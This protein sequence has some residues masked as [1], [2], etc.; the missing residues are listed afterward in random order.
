[1]ASGVLLKKEE[2]TAKETGNQYLRV[3]ISELGDVN[4]F[5]KLAEY[6]RTVPVGQS[7]TYEAEQNGKYMNLKE[8]DGHTAFGRKGG[9]G[10]EGGEKRAAGPGEGKAAYNSDGGKFNPTTMLL[11]YEKDILISAKHFDGKSL[12]DVRKWMV[13][14]YEFWEGFTKQR[15]A[16]SAPKPV[17]D[18]KKPTMVQLASIDRL[19]DEIGL[20]VEQLEAYRA[21]RWGKSYTQTVAEELRTTLEDC[22]NQKLCLDFD[23][24]AEIVFRAPAS[25]S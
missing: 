6:M 12:D 25:K 15:Q 9:G 1:M 24:K 17:A 14:A 13:G 21:K 22:V 11:S 16:A 4:V 18:E 19:R 20:T 2:K 7:V 3:T 8:V 23:E 5:K 10:G